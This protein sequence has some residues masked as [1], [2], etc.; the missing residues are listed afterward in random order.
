MPRRKIRFNGV[1]LAGGLS[2]R[3]G[4]DKALLRFGEETLLTRAKAVL[5]EAG[6]AQVFVSRNDQGE[7]HLADVYPQHGP[8]SGIHAALLADDNP[9]LAMPVDMPLIDAEAIAMLFNNGAQM[10]TIVTYVDHNLPIY[11]PNNSAIRRYLEQTLTSDRNK[12]IT[13]FMQSLGCSYLSPLDADKLINVNTPQQWR[14]LQ[15]SV[16]NRSQSWHTN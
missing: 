9:I 8:L 16:N 6:A 2:S 14:Q 12:S 4:Q 7:G 10:D 1:V 15:Q 13:R 5:K 3:M 11:V